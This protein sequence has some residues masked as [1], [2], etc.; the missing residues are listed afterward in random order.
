MEIDIYARYRGQ[1]DEE[2]RDQDRYYATHDG[3]R[4]GYLRE[5]YHLGP[6]AT[7][8]LCREAFKEVTGQ[9]PIPAAILR[10]RLPEARRLAEQCERDEYGHP[11]ARQIHHVCGNVTAFVE[12][13]E[14]VERTTGEPVT[15]VAAY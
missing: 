3:G 5:V 4:F 14:R 9:A 12:F 10:R 8:F 2:L 11:F 13:C 6:Y 7:A 15:I 1:T